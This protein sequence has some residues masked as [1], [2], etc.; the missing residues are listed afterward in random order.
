MRKFA[1]RIALV[2]GGA[3]G[4]GRALC[5]QLAGAGA[6]VVVT[7]INAPGAEKVAAEIRERGGRATAQALDVSSETE[8]EQVVSEVSST[9]K[10][11]DYIFNNAAAAIVGEF[12]DGNLADFRR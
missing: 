3:A 6:F 8:V 10:R 1:D 4:I 9:H 11:L 7:D 12:R 5:E 2:T